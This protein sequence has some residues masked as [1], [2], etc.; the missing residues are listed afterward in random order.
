[1]KNI[2]IPEEISNINDFEFYFTVL[3]GN[4][5]LKLSGAELIKKTVDIIRHYNKYYKKWIVNYK[6]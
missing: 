5:E 1:M 3:L 2:E 6:K 4:C